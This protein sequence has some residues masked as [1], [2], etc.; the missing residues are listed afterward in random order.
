MNLSINPSVIIF[1]GTI[2]MI[3]FLSSKPAQR[4]KLID[5]VAKYFSRKKNDQ[6]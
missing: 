3:L 1:L 5:L 4:N 2:F 6:E